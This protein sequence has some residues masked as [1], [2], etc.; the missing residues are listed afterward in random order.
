MLITYSQF[1]SW[2]NFC[3]WLDARWYK[4]AYIEHIESA[5]EREELKV[6]PFV[7]SASGRQARSLLYL[8]HKIQFV[9]YRLLPVVNYWG[10]KRLKGEFGKEVFYRRGWCLVSDWEYKIDFLEQMI[11]FNQSSDRLWIPRLEARMAT[12]A[13]REQQRQFDRRRK[14]ELAKKTKV[15]RYLA[16]YCPHCS[17]PVVSLMLDYPSCRRGYED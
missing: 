4:F 2:R 7:Y 15:E 17:V 10:E 12:R 13:E 16:G 14:D 3:E 6:L 11:L 1:Y 9:S 5:I 8:N